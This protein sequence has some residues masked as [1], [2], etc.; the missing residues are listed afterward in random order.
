MDGTLLFSFAGTHVATAKCVEGN[1]HIW[2]ELRTPCKAPIGQ[3]RKKGIQPDYTIALE[4]VTHPQSTRVVVE[5]K[6]YAKA[7]AKS[8]AEALIDYTKGRP[9]AR[10][11]LVNYG[12]APQQILERIPEDL[13][14]RAF[15]LGY[16]RPGQQNVLTTFQ[17]LIRESLPSPL[18]TTSHRQVFDLI[19]VDISGSMAQHLET[20][21]AL[22]I[23]Q[24]TVC[25]SPGARL[26]AIDTD[27]RFQQNASDETLQQILALP[28][29]G[30]T[31]LPKALSRY[32]LSQGFV[33]TDNDGWQQLKRS[34]L[35]PK[36]TLVF[37]A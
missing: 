1:L 4:P 3:S 31:D 17:C 34:G 16:F 19:A 36:I 37:G 15:L 30:G 5:A 10:V 25:N 21:E 33:I 24:W 8:F 13:R 9:K 22:E 20:I 18:V 26:L 27:I 11:I 29:R 23:L 35:Q 32:D 6:Q 14:S 7:S 2:C 12:P 28:R